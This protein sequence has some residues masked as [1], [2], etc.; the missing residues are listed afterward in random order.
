[1]LPDRIL[2]SAEL[3]A[4]EKDNLRRALA[5][6]GGKVSGKN[7]AAVLLGMKPT[8]VYSRIKSLQLG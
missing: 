8:T 1:M 3:A 7:G 4:L 6:S 5:A 2:T